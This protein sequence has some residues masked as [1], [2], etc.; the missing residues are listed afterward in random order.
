MEHKELWDLVWCL[1]FRPQLTNSPKKIAQSHCPVGPPAG[2]G[3][4]VGCIVRRGPDIHSYQQNDLYLQLWLLMTTKI[5]N[6]MCRTLFSGALKGNASAKVGE[7]VLVT[8]TPL[9][10]C[11]LSLLRLGECTA[12]PWTDADH[13]LLWI[14]TPLSA[15]G[16]SGGATVLV[17]SAFLNHIQL[18]TSFHFVCDK[19]MPLTSFWEALQWRTI[20]CVRS[21]YT[22]LGGSIS[23][24]IFLT[25]PK[26]VG[27]E[28]LW[29]FSP[30]MYA[31]GPLQPDP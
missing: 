18:P 6:T 23:S 4:G 17:K 31:L 7:L 10:V 26:V 29:A 11:K 2:R 5:C 13:L 1:V 27:T 25:S 28:T 3:I 8:N 19:I 22:R 30:L 24:S 20:S 16:F 12:T 14:L 21:V 9:P 15:G